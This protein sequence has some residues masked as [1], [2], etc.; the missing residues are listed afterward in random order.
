M[1]TFFFRSGQ[2]ALESVKFLNTSQSCW[3]FIFGRIK[4]KMM[5]SYQPSP[6]LW[7][8]HIFPILI[9]R[10]WEMYFLLLCFVSLMGKCRNGLRESP[11]MSA[12]RPRVTWRMAGNRTTSPSLS[13][14]P[15]ADIWMSSL[16]TDEPSRSDHTSRCAC[17]RS[18]LP[19]CMHSIHLYKN[20]AVCN[21]LQLNLKIPLTDD[22]EGLKSIWSYGWILHCLQNVLNSFKASVSK[23]LALTCDLPTTKRAAVY[24]MF[25]TM[26]SSLYDGGADEAFL[27]SLCSSYMK[28]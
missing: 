28:V 10:V 9:L 18:P 3:I 23:I 19:A 13:R 7:W 25:G 15:L 26:G 11:G 22:M 21:T 27:C 4:C 16:S 24:F 1:V 12:W 17:N 14:V 8:L 20:T 6:T 2:V 5:A